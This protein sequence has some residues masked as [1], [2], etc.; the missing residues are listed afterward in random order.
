MLIYSISSSRRKNGANKMNRGN[1]FSVAI[2]AFHGIHVYLG[3]FRY[4]V[5]LCLFFLRQFFIEKLAAIAAFFRI[6]KDF[7]GA[8]GAFFVFR[9][10][11]LLFMSVSVVQRLGFAVR[12]VAASNRGDDFSLRR[13]G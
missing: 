2:R 7:F 8:V 4:F 5:F 12:V 1:Y 3:G 13:L 9:H 6:C 11:W 10:D